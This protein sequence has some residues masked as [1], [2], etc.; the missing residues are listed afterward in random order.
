MVCF[1]YYH[2]STAQHDLHGR[3]QKSEDELTRLTYNQ[4]LIQQVSV[5]AEILNDMASGFLGSEQP[6][7][8]SAV[9]VKVRSFS[10][11]T[12]A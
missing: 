6:Q 1:L 5:I 9:K 3:Q 7:W 2:I 10:I 8:P 11:I 12:L 4:S